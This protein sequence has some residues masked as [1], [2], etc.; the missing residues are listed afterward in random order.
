VRKGYLQV[1]TTIDDRER[2]EDLVRDVVERR[3][4]ACGQVFGPIESTYR[5]KGR[6]EKEQEWMCVFKTA[7]RCAPALEAFLR[8]V[9]PYEV[10]EIV[11]VTLDLVSSDYGDWIDD[12]TEV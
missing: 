1:Q 11:G 8:D 7:A 12:E 4:A 9:H 5:W 3:L 2:A 10:P 6:I